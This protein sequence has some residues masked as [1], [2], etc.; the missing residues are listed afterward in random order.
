LSTNN[1]HFTKQCDFSIADEELGAGGYV[2]LYG[3]VAEDSSGSICFERAAAYSDMGCLSAGEAM[4]FLAAL[5]NLKVSDPYAFR[6]DFSG[7]QLS[8]RWIYRVGNWYLSGGKLY[9]S[10]SGFHAL[11]CDVTAG[12]VIIRCTAQTF[13]S[14]DAV[15]LIALSDSSANGIIGW[16]S[17]VT[18]AIAER[19]GASLWTWFEASDLY[20]TSNII[21]LTLAVKDG[22]A[23]L[24]MDNE[25]VAMTKFSDYP[26]SETA[27]IGLA[28]Y[29]GSGTGSLCFYSFE[30]DQWPE[31]IDVMTIRPGDTCGSIM[32]QLADLTGGEFFCR[33]DGTL[34]YGHI[35][36]GTAIAIDDLIL[37]QESQ[38]MKDQLLTQYR[39]TG[40][41]VAAEV[42][43]IALAQYLGG[44]R[45]ETQQIG[46]SSRW[47]CY[48]A[49]SQMLSKSRRI[50][51]YSID[52]RAHP[53]L[54]LGDLISVGD[55][56]FVLRAFSENLD[57]ANYNISLNN[58]QSTEEFKIEPVT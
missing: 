40:S 57:V 50:E 30:V 36:S 1:R 19:N 53:G 20:V 23:C 29:S 54:E 18:A 41:N 26:P 48:Y 5:S 6:D 35:G 10:G 8:P 7:S 43:D 39:V 22:H 31:P 49:A 51:T 2:G 32:A 4:G 33:A 46:S 16:V 3:Y 47:D 52:I 27:Y 25:L 42:R 28:C 17:A 34:Y 14:L 56:T 13:S 55:N 24:Y 12:N 37:R 58:L 11:L 15:G 45:Y 44:H 21:S 9:A 38:R